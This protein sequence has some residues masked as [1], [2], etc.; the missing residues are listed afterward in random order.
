MELRHRSSFLDP[1]Y[2]AF[3][4]CT[5]AAASAMA[6][7]DPEEKIVMVYSYNDEFGTSA[8]DGV[9][10]GGRAEQLWHAMKASLDIGFRMG[11]Y[12]SGYP[13]D[14]VPLQAADLLAYELSK[15]L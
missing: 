12:A 8:S 1:Y 10:I 7:S 6:E 4:K 11:A 9:N 13:R 5:R 14:I 3:Q 2:H 15:E